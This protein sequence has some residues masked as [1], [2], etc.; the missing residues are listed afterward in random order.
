LAEQDTSE[1]LVD[2]VGTTG[3]LQ[4]QAES[5][6]ALSPREQALAYWLSEASI[7]IDPIAYNQNSVFGLR[8]KRILD[9]I[10][11]AKVS[12]PRIISFVKLFWANHGNHND[13][14]AQKFLP[15]FSFEELKAAAFL[16]LGPGEDLVRELDE[17]RPS[18]FDPDFQKLLTAKNP[19][20]ALDIVQA[21]AN[22]FYSG[23]TLEDLKGFQERY[24]LNSRLVKAPDGRLEEQVWRTGTTDGKIKG[25]P[26]AEFLARAIKFLQR[27]QKYAEPRQSEAISILIRYYQTGDPADWVRFNTVWVGENSR[28]DFTNGFIEVYRDARAAKGL[29]QA[30][31]CVTD[32]KLNQEMLELAA[33]AQYFENKAPWAPQYKKKGVKPPIAKAVEAIV[34]T[35][36]FPVGITGDNLPNENEI[37]EKFGSKNF[38]FTG[39]MRAFRQAAGWAVLEEFGE[40]A[41][42]I[43]ICK[44]YSD[45][46]SNLIIALHEV[47][48]HGSGQLS[49][50]LQGGAQ[51]YLR[52][53]FS[54]L[55][56]ARADLMALW[57]VSDPKLRELGLVSDPNVAVAMYYDAVRI[58][59]TQLRYIPNGD[60]IE[61]DHFRNRQLILNYIR[62]KTQ[63]IEQVERDGKTYLR[64]RN[65][66]MMHDGVG[67]LLAE[68]MRI[69]AEGDYQ[70]I[71]TL[72][73]KYAVH[74]EPTLRD[75]VV[76]RYNKLGL[77]TYWC[78]INPT[79][80]AVLDEGENVK[81][82]TMS[83]PRDFVQQQMSYS[84]ANRPV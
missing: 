7:A 50:K 52:E 80:T 56:E 8:Q 74:F 68:L 66:D 76:A 43:E 51:P 11:R 75:Q 84:A 5:F 57:S 72:V 19:E 22:N 29:S 70:A 62:D 9:A 40:S 73:D 32:E 47:V 45:E 10:M 34:E 58:V 71:K 63:A 15:E 1:V 23:V 12:D 26:Y 17:L 81:S 4:L 24:P 65:F 79:L 82:V 41:D 59:L 78:G 42:E 16:A 53:Y 6:R 69:K 14:T 46:A 18:L 54:T 49:P 55:E 35:G 20:G 38:I 77:P 2:R 27:A 21:S 28:V 3:F 33:N 13:L 60:I 61:E 30:F 39:S 36:G 37:R 67:M 48:G 44:K 31:V 83:Y 64:L 25:G